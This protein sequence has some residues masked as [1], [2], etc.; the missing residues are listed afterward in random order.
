MKSLSFAC[1]ALVVAPFS[2]AQEGKPTSELPNP[3]TAAHA[4]L[5]A[6]AGEWTSAC[7]LRAVPGLPGHEAAQKSSGIE[8]A[9]LICDGLWLKTTFHGQHEGG[10][11][12]GLWLVG[13]DPLQKQYRGIWVSSMD[14]PCME[15]VGSHDAATKT[16]TFTGE[17][18]HGAFRS[19]VTFADADHCT[20]VCYLVADGKETEC[21]RIE[22]K[23][24]PGA[25]RA[26]EASVPPKKWPSAAHELLAKGVGDWEARTTCMAPGQKPVVETGRERVLPICGGRWFWSDFTGTMMGQPFQGHSLTGY[27]A[28]QQRYVAFW[29]DST[30]PMRSLTH[31]THDPKTH[32]WTFTGE[33]VD[34]AGKP[35]K[36]HQTYVQKDADT[37]A[38][39]MTFEGPDGKQEMKVDYARKAR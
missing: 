36:I 1:A 14:E 18:S 28:G 6:F 39:Q 11:F 30:S 3:K 4:A 21:M 29:I 9:E 20:E 17:S 16:W 8:R 7:D 32:A 25:G 13:Y 35:A 37:R 15:C 31:G 33:C 19:V 24:Q 23:R 10:P 2:I 22:R 27:D 26:V 5:A 38:L 34:M 12:E